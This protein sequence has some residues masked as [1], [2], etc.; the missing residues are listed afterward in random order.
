VPW[1]L[2]I[3][4]SFA[5][6][7]GASTFLLCGPGGRVLEWSW[8]LCPLSFDTR[9]GRRSSRKRPAS[10]GIIGEATKQ[11]A[12]T[13]PWAIGPTSE[14]HP[15]SRSVQMGAQAGV[16]LPRLREH[17]PAA[18][19]R[20]RSRAGRAGPML[21]AKPRP[22]AAETSVGCSK[23][24]GTERPFRCG[25][26]ITAQSIPSITIAPATAR[27][28]IAA[29]RTVTPLLIQRRSCSCLARKAACRGAVRGIATNDIG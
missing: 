16:L 17:H 2:R 25:A 7:P 23:C 24:L 19:L 26:F 29:T 27:T 9:P 10:K 13:P 5:S 4:R 1:Q 14:P 28:A 6:V 8:V 21:L 12:S 22:S 3:A 18:R 15:R 11:G 20:V